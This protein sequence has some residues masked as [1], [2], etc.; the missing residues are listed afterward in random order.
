MRI[1]LVV[2]RFEPR[3]GGVESA[4]WQIAHGLAAAGEEVHVFSRQAGDTSAVSVHRVYTPTFWQPLRL[5]LFSSRARRAIEDSTFDVVHSFSRTRH[6]DIFHAGGGSHAEYMRLTYGSLG[7]LARRISPRHALQL[8]MERKIFADPHQL[9]QCVSP[10]VRDDIARGYDVPEDRLVVVPYGVDCQQ[11]APEKHRPEREGLRRQWSSGGKSV[12]LLAGSGWHRKGLDTAL[13]ALAASE[14]R[15]QFLWVAGRDQ[16]R[17]WQRLAERLG[18]ADRV[19]FLGARTD[20]PRI[21]AA[22]DGLLLP[23]RYDAFGLVLLEAAASG[24]PVITSGSA[25]AA[26]LLAS[27]GIVIAQA[28]DVDGFASALDQLENPAERRKL[29]DR[30]R[31]I[32]LRNGWR[33]TTD[34][35]RALYA[36]TQ[37]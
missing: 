21:Y 24:L 28:G 25:G 11:F 6:Q 35:L 9:I 19:R 22:A 8:F 12:W 37:P 18:V 3:G 13:R 1:A 26:S 27:A 16:T 14:S 15:S 20:M 33:E 29:G 23:T 36:R 2:E 31:E 30:G 5:A 34:Q 4:S 17:A 10:M 32:A 7:A